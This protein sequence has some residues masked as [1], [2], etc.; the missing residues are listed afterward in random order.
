MT[1]VP[2]DKNW[3]WVLE[4][5]C[6]DC[7]FDAPGFDRAKVGSTV[8]SIAE[9]W[10]AVLGRDSVWERPGPSIWSPLE[11]ACHVR[12]VFRIFDGRLERML[13]EDH[14][15]FLNWDQDQ[16]AVDDR[17]GEQDPVAVSADLQAFAAQIAARFETVADTQWAHTGARSD[18]AVF[19]VDSFA[20]YFLHD[21]IHHLW[22]VTDA[23]AAAGPVSP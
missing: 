20:R 2:E 10:V 22:D 4:R 14:P 5:R 15:E 8:R 12:D 6:P 23:A 17:Y 13:S 19:T 9:R 3:T 21:P 16:T 1:I 18:G 7:G 11:Y